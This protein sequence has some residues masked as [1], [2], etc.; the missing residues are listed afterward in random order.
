MKFYMT[1]ISN[2]SN[3]NAKIPNNKI[4]EKLKDTL[5]CQMMAERGGI[6]THE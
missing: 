5:N 4:S 1:G 2:K 6:R 3:E